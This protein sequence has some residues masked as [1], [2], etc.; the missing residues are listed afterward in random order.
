MATVAHDMAGTAPKT[1]AG[2][3]AKAVAK[4]P[5]HLFLIAMALFWMIPTFGLL[6][7]SFRTAEASSSSGWWTAL[8]NP[9]ELTLDPYRNILDDA[10]FVKAIFNTILI[11]GPASVLVVLIAALAA[12]A[13]A[14]VD[15][16]GREPLFLVVVGLI[17]ATAVLS[18]IFFGLVPALSAAGA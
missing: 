8:P 5:L 16:R 12:Y 11:T 13:F 17:V 14:W 9:A 4:G 7:T 1:R 10:G 2:R 18:G 3:I 6:V 15:F